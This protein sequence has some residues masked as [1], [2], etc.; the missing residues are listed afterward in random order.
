MIT[1]SMSEFIDSLICDEFQVETN[2]ALAAFRKLFHPVDQFFV[3]YADDI[4]MGFEHRAEAERF[5]QDWRERPRMTMT[6]PVARCFRQCCAQRSILQPSATYESG[7]VFF[8]R[9]SGARCR[10]RVN[11]STL[12]HESETCSGSPAISS[13]AFAPRPPD[14]PPASLMDTDYAITG[15][16]VRRRRPQIRFL[17]I[18]PYLCSTLPSDATSRWR[19]CASLPFTSIRLGRDF[20]PLAVE[21]AGRTSKKGR[22]KAAPTEPKQLPELASQDLADEN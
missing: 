9:R 8:G 15:P 1:D 12:S 13:T 18:G 16:L 6:S 17:S 5:L 11:Y 21:H 19:P 7:A 20:H 4:V 2:A 3:R 14:L 10:I 22:R